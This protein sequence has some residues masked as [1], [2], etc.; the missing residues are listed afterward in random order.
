MDKK[1]QVTW[2]PS[3]ITLYLSCTC[4][5]TAQYNCD[6]SEGMQQAM[7]AFYNWH[8]G[9]GHKPCDSKTASKVRRGK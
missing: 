3:K 1:I 5:L 4:G 7:N 8:S 2:E 9:E 6:S